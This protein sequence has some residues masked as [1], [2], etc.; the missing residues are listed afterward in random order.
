[1]KVFSKLNQIR[2]NYKGAILYSGLSQ[3]K[4]S[5]EIRAFD[6]EFYASLKGKYYN[7]IPVYYYLLRMSMGK[8]YDASAILGLAL[9]DCKICRVF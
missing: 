7:G 3:K 5:G 6:E 2:Q 9:G 1:M 4:L 8:C